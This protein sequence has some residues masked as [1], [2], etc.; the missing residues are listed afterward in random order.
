MLLVGNNGPFVA[1][2]IIG[3]NYIVNY[4]VYIKEN[5]MRD[6]LINECTQVSGGLSGS[7]LI[8]TGLGV[9]GGM[10]ASDFV[11]HLAPLTTVIGTAMS[12]TILA[13]TF[14]ICC[15][16]CGLVFGAGFGAVTGYLFSA[17]TAKTGAFVVGGMIIGTASYA[18]L[19]G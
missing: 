5:D 18:L 19:N 15:G 3:A 7:A 14:M 13:G 4:M 17:Q 1:N 11:S 9:A 16:P 2:R 6:L 8:A 10:L 12:A